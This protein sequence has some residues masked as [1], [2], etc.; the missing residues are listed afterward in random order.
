MI[1]PPLRAIVSVS[2]DDS[3]SPARKPQREPLCV[4][5]RNDLVG[6][7]HRQVAGR[8]GTGAG[9]V[10]WRLFDDHEIAQCQVF[11]KRAH[12]PDPDDAFHP[13][14]SQFHHR[15][16]GGCPADSGRAD[17]DAPAVETAH[18]HAKLAVLP[19]EFEIGENACRH[20]HTRRVP[21]QQKIGRHDLG[22]GQ[23]H[24]VVALPGPGRGAIDQRHESNHF[25]A[26]AST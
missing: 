23:V 10:G 21:R 26:C 16:L 5:R 20:I 13:Q 3:T 17:T 11:G 9:A 12:A 25:S 6:G 22:P 4:E 7:A 15:D 19:D 24:R 1:R 14:R 2:G 8:I 18:A